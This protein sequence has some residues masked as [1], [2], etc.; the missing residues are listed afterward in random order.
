MKNAKLVL[1][2]SLFSMSLFSQTDTSYVYF[3]IVD[4]MHYTVDE[5][6]FEDVNIPPMREVNKAGADSLAVIDFLTN[7]IATRTNAAARGVK[8]S[9]E[10]RG[11]LSGVAALLLDFSGESYYKHTAQK[12]ENAFTGDYKIWVNGVSYDASMS[13][14][15][16]GNMRL[17]IPELTN[18]TVW[19]LGKNSF[20]VRN[21]T[22]EH[23]RY[24]LIRT[25][26][27]KKEY[28]GIDSDNGWKIRSK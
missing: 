7:K 19:I 15:P 11:L 20:E 2:L 12:Y 17:Y 10:N 28:R 3:S 5:T 1:I 8:H 23:V 14:T 26:N 6:F 16:A 13:L 27:G 18:Y 21:Y 4:S 22:P 9:Y 24:S 25:I